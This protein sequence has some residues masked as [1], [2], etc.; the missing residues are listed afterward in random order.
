MGSHGAASSQAVSPKSP[1]LGG[2]G[3]HACDAL[4]SR[5]MAGSEKP[6]LTPVGRA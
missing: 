4:V 5:A 6:F 2:T 3:G 1:S